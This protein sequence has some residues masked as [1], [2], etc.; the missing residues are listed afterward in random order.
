MNKK[1]RKMLENQ[2]KL[3]NIIIGLIGLILDLIAI[4]LQLSNVLQNIFLSVGCS[5]IATSIA[6][7]LTS[8]Y[9]INSNEM[10]EIITNWKLQGIFKTKSEMNTKSNECLDN[11]KKQIDIIAIGM[12]NFLSCKRN[13]LEKKA[14]N[15]VNIR[16]ISCDNLSMLTQRE[17]DETIGGN[18]NVIGTMRN[19]VEALTEWV[20]SVVNKNGNIAI[21]YHSTYPGFSY[22]RIDDNVFFGPN[23]PLYKSQINFALEFN[24]NGKGGQYFNEYFNSLWD[25]NNICSQILNFKE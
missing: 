13:V 23:L 1:I 5:L 15:G 14:T 16:I 18:G 24:I 20:Q 25:N 12:A 19:E 10:K 21:K 8:F 17:K 22:L 2:S 3:T 11:A 9:L 6:T 4:T 7:W